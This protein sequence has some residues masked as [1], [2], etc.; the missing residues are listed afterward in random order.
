M[1]IPHCFVLKINP[2]P[3]PHLSSMNLQGY[4]LFPCS[5]FICRGAFTLC[6]HLEDG[7]TGKVLVVSWIFLN[8]SLNNISWIQELAWTYFL[9]PCK[10]FLVSFWIFPGIFPVIFWIFLEVFEYFLE[11]FLELFKYFW[12]FLNITRNFP[13]TFWILPGTLNTF[14]NFF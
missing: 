8:I 7:E 11:S 10:N 2:D 4:N 6:E 12:N 14:W 1:A 5:L 9:E 3:R 13:G